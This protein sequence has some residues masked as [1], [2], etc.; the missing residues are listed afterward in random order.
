[1]VT[2]GSY[3]FL[4]DPALL[5][6]NTKWLLH[7]TWDPWLYMCLS[8]QL[9]NRLE[10]V[11]ML[12]CSRHWASI[13]FIYTHSHPPGQDLIMHLGEL[14]LK[15]SALPWAVDKSEI[16]ESTVSK[17]YT[18]QN[19]SSFSILVLCFLNWPF[20]SNQVKKHGAEHPFP[21]CCSMEMSVKME[22]FYICDVQ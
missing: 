19:L 9:K 12:L 7:C 3:W 17:L 14:R 16:Q 8:L 18:T 4:K 5:K 22:T 2:D 6:G 10:H 1:M 15:N 20:P 11:Y 21:M 13:L